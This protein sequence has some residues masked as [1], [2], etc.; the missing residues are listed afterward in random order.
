MCTSAERMFN[1]YLVWCVLPLCF[2]P[3]SLPSLFFHPLGDVE[4]HSSLV[5]ETHSAIMFSV[6]YGHFEHRWSTSGWDTLPCPQGRGSRPGVFPHSGWEHLA[7]SDCAGFSQIL[8]P[9]ALW[10][11]GGS[12]EQIL[13]FAPEGPLNLGEWPQ[14][15]FQTSF[16]PGGPAYTFRP[17]SY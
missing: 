12:D 4:F 8:H 14:W 1:W 11:C 16:L 10:L 6:P 15:L 3:P 2:S 9:H 17:A 13:W 5:S 7:P